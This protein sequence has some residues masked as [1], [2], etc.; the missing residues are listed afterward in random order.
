[1]REA[2]ITEIAGTITT[3]DGVTR[4]FY[5]SGEGGSQWGATREQLG[6]TV[7][8]LEDVC[9]ALAEGDYLAS[10]EDLCDDCGA[11]VG[12]EVKAENATDCCVDCYYDHDEMAREGE[13]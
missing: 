4:Q 10:Y 12:R 3:S 6:D 7:D 2:R 8:A 5:I 11:Y 13:A 1:M 9:K